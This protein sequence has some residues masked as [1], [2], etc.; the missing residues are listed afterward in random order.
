MAST[1]YRVVRLWE[2]GRKGS[3]HKGTFRTDGKNLYSYNLKI[4]TTSKSGQKVLFDYSGPW[5]VS[6]TTSNH[7]G[8]A[9]SYGPTLT[10]NPDFAHLLED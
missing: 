3:N 6:Q 1:N 10:I 9:R 4:G 7:V 5:G 8:I 2:K